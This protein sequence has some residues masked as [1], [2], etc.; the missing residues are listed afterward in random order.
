MPDQRQARLVA[1]SGT[2]SDTSHSSSERPRRSAIWAA[3]R[4]PHSQSGS[5]AALSDSPNGVI[6]YSTLGGWIA[7]RAGGHYATRLTL[8][9]DLVESLRAVT[10]AGVEYVFVDTAR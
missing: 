1:R 8:I 4:S 7:T 3:L 10:P 5:S 6:E 2:A 9:D